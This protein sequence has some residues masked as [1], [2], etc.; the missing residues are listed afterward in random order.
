MGVGLPLPPQIKGFQRLPE[1]LSHIGLAHQTF[2][3]GSD[4]LVAGGGGESQT[5]RRT[6]ELTG[7]GDDADLGKLLHIGPAHNTASSAD[8]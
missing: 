3:S 1:A 6:I 7:A 2:S 5:F 4:C 8:E